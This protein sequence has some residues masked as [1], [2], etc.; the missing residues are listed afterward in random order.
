M[1][2]GIFRSGA[3]LMLTSVALSLISVGTPLIF[4]AMQPDHEWS[5]WLTGF[6]AFCLSISGAIIA[7]LYII[8]FVQYSFSK[9]Y[10][11]WLTVWLLLGNFPGLIILLSLP[12]LKGDSTASRIPA[13]PQNSHA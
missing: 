10:G 1:K 2:T 3:V 11:A 6:P 12:D 5:M 9:G 8:G 4:A 13:R 7:L